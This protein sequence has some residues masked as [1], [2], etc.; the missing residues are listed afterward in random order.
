L[1]NVVPA[2][3]PWLAI[4]TDSKQPT[5]CLGVTL[6]YVLCFFEKPFATEADYSKQQ[7][8]LTNA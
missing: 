1:L 6:L 4:E 2:K 7:F 3:Y 8:E 5:F